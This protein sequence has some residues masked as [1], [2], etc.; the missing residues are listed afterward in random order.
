MVENL[1]N[2]TGWVSQFD[3]NAGIRRRI[4]L[5]GNVLDIVTDDSH[6]TELKIFSLTDWLTHRLRS[7]GFQRI[8]LYDCDKDFQILYWGGQEL[9]QG[10]DYIRRLGQREGRPIMSTGRDLQPADILSQL[11]LFLSC[12]DA[13]AAVII[14]NADLRFSP[15]SHGSVCLHKLGTDAARVRLAAPSQ[16]ENRGTDSTLPDSQTENLPRGFL[17]N[18]AIYLYLSD[19]GI[20]PQFFG[21]DPEAKLIRIPFPDIAQ[22]VRY[23]QHLRRDFFE[24]DN[25]DISLFAKQTEG[26]KLRELEILADISRQEE[27]PPSRFQDL[28]K[29][30]FIGRRQDRW[31]KVDVAE[32]KRLILKR[33]RIRG[34]DEAVNEVLD[35]VVTGKHRMVE[36][37]DPDT[38]KPPLLLFLVGPTGVG[39]NL[40]CRELANALGFGRDQVKILDMSEYRQ[41]HTD[42]KL[43]GAPPSYVGYDQ[44]GQLTNFVEAQGFCMV[45]IDEIEKAHER[46]A[47]IWLQVT[48]GAR[49]TDGKGKTVDFTDVCLVFTSNIGSDAIDLNPKL[50]NGNFER[51]DV[52][53]HFTSKV[54]E[55]FAEDLERP[56]L[57]NRLKRGLVVFNFI[58]EAQALEVILDLLESLVRQINDKVELRNN[59][60]VE[61]TSSDQPPARII[62]D[63]NGRNEKELSNKLLGKVDYKKYGLRDVNTMLERTVAPRLALGFLEKEHIQGTFRLLW[64]PVKECVE[65]ERDRN[66]AN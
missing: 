19:S 20:P 13:P 15:P 47:D 43:I 49:L 6:G 59:D 33:R 16:Q 30:Y 4:V 63:R 58:E 8:V 7:R 66:H 45:I 29:H 3:I 21:T 44:G 14:V 57:Y 64:D 51:K 38:Q 62:F 48:E 40:L 1:R 31:S 18:I 35:R 52:V 12:D 10:F 50:V 9:S 65:I 24:P 53:D 37:I 41:E 5:H 17:Q 42:Q 27:I 22:R 32:A 11:A 2:T 23:I 54:E 56:E 36:M 46:L 61:N 55:Y 39:K 34:Q 25:I 60:K 28:E 26:W